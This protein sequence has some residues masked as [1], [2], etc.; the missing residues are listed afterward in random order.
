MRNIF[1]KFKN[2]KVLAAAAV[3][4]LGGGYFG[5]NF[6]AAAPADARYVLA[7]VTKGTLITSVS[8]T[9]QVSASNQ[10]DIKPSV[11]GD[12]VNIAIVNGQSVKAGSLLVQLDD[13]NAQKTVRDASANLDGAKLSLQKLQQPADSLSILQAENTLSQAEDSLAKLKLS[14]QIDYQKAVEAKQNADSDLKKAYDDGFNTVSN[15]FLDLPGVMTGLQDMLYGTSLNAGQANVSYYSDAVKGY[16]SR[17][18]QYKDDVDMNYQK[19]RDEYNQ[20]FAD[21]KAATRSSDTATIESLINETYETTKSIAETVKSANNLIQFYEDKLAEHGLKPPAAANTHLTT[22]NTYTTKTNQFLGDL[23]AIQ[24]TLKQ[25]KDSISSAE[26]DLQ[27]MDQNNPF[28]LAAAGQ[29]VQEKTISLAKLKAGADPLDIQSQ[30]L[31]VKQKEN[32]LLDAEATLADYRIKAPFDG[33]IAAVNVK[34]GDSISAGT[35]IAT[36]ITTQK[37][38][39]ISVNEVDAVKIK[40]GQKAT[41]T[42]DAI[43]DLSISGE[44]AQI[45]A[46]GTVTQGVVNYNV[47]ISFD[48]QDD[49]IKSGMSVS[50]AVITD[51]RQDVL[52]VPNGAIKSKGQASYVET[53]DASVAD[54]QLSAASTAGVVSKNPPKQ[55]SVEIGLANDSDTEIISGLNEG[56]NVVIRTIAAAIQ[57]K[58]A[59]TTSSASAGLRIPGLTGGGSGGSF[60]GGN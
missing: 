5:Y 27:T 45:D 44:V 32:A 57:T 33:I 31:A 2:R 47:K 28:D 37:I 30:Q 22:L 23:L 60:R 1:K 16:D 11:A 26:S 35:V 34:K 9:G 52:L 29:S 46:I 54:S 3:I 25:S 55:Q 6:L 43:T 51:A 7:K 56:D 59:A 48:T 8:G 15:T 14:Q 17:V 21:Y 18:V 50:V 4:I 41:L 40:V 12:A 49:R 13:Q 42:F 19:A 20:N 36:L 10:L 53:I 39:T 24:N 58:A 38:A